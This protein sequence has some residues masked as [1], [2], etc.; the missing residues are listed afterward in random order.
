MFY[1]IE[2]FNTRL[3]W[4][5]ERA[6]FRVTSLYRSVT[7]CFTLRHVFTSFWLNVDANCSS[8]W[9][10]MIIYPSPFVYLCFPYL[11]YRWINNVENCRDKI[12]INK[13]T[14]LHFATFIF[15]KVSRRPERSNYLPLLLLSN[16]IRESSLNNY[17]SFHNLIHGIILQIVCRRISLQRWFLVVVLT[18]AFFF[19]Q[20]LKYVCIHNLSMEHD[21][22]D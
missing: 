8:C 20:S 14:K 15:C 10:R 13:S 11:R 21:R 19:F 7:R 16:L 6:L 17:F 9:R 22:S 4:M 5:R 1:G 12:S 18:S 2:G 3:N